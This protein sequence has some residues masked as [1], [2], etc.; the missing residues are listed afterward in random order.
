[1]KKI[2]ILILTKTKMI[3]KFF[4]NIVDIILK[5]KINYTF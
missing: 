2:K 5:K 4:D 1:M 3:M